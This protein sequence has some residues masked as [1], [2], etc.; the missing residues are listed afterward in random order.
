MS[1]EVLAGFIGISQQQISRYERGEVDLTLDKI[2]TIS[3]FF[4]ITIWEFMELLYLFYSP[5]NCDF[6]HEIKSHRD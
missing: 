4:N 6:T 1:G 5:G 2:K 3:S